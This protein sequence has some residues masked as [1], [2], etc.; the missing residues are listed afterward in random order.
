MK[1][2]YINNNSSTISVAWKYMVYVFRILNIIDFIFLTYNFC[3]NFC[4]NS[5]GV[6]HMQIILEYI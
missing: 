2:S 4:M 3:Y 5:L 6:K 1:G